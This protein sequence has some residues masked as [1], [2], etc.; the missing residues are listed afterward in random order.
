MPRRDQRQTGS[1]RAA[2]PSKM[3]S[4]HPPASSGFKPGPYARDRYLREIK[5]LTGRAARRSLGAD[6]RPATA[7]S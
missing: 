7:R 5:S 3:D 4:V 2:K 1:T 6:L